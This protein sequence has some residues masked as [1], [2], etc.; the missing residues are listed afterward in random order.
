[1]NSLTISLISLLLGAI[2]VGLAKVLQDEYA[3]RTEAQGAAVAI[4]AEIS[5]ILDNVRR[6]RYV[7]ILDQYIAHMSDLPAL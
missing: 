7:E 6:G 2:V 1:M 5:M 4:G 3:R